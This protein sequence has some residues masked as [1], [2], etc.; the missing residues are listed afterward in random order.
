[1]K[2]VL[3]TFLFFYPMLLWAEVPEY[4]IVTDG[5]GAVTTIPLADK[6]VIKQKDGQ[7]IVVCKGEEYTFDVES[8]LIVKFSEQTPDAIKGI[9]IAGEKPVL[10][11]GRAIFTGLK[12]G[13][14][15]AIFST[16]GAKMRTTKADANGNAVIDY[17]NLPQGVYILKG[18]KCSTKVRVRK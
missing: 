13:E 1:M 11:A 3:L 12:A 16:S 5:D 14:T 7:L 2:K 8:G 9:E 6:P 10:E 4:L 15:V 17:D 18:G